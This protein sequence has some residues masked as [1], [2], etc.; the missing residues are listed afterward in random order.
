MK[1]ITFGRIICIIGLALN[2]PACV[3]TPQLDHINTEALN[4]AKHNFAIATAELG[5]AIESCSN[6]ATQ[7]PIPKLNSETLAELNVDRKELLVG[8]AHLSFRNM[9]E[10]ERAARAKMAL[11]TGTLSQVMADLDLKSSEIETIGRVMIYPPT[12][13][14]RY[15]ARFTKLEGDLRSYL[16]NVVGTRPF[17]IIE[18]LDANGLAPQE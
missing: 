6:Q 17:L 18:A 9:F 16:E 13:H 4:I 11:A 1:N 10:C 5:E 3:S 2:L 12:E 8:L 7:T 14:L 15:R